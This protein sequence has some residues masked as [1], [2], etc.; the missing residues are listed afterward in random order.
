MH[1]LCGH[2][3]SSGNRLGNHSNNAFANAFDKASSTLQID[4]AGNTMSSNSL[5]AELHTP[6]FAPL[7]GSVTKPVTPLNTPVAYTKQDVTN[8]Q[9]RTAIQQRSEVTLLRLRNNSYGAHVTSNQDQTS[10]RI[11]DSCRPAVSH[12]RDVGEHSD[13]DWH[14]E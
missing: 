8:R 1:Y 6:S 10:C 11:P 14:S 5:W 2:I 4:I 12:F 9:T 3:N 13:S 7:R